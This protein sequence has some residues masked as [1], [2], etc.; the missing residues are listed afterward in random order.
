MEELNSYTGL[1]FSVRNVSPSAEQER[2]YDNRWISEPERNLMLAV[3][4]DAIGCFLNYR[5]GDRN[6][7]N[8]LLY[9]DARD[10]INSRS[11]YSI[12]AFR[13]LCEIVGINPDAL[14]RQLHRIRRG[15]SPR[16]VS[17]QRTFDVR[18]PSMSNT[19]VGARART[20]RA[21]APMPV[22]AGLTHP[23][24]AIA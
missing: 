9:A 20:R 22:S 8:R 14:K 1:P 10:W 16:S 17:L 13:N 23:E 21:R 11:R 2:C 5:D 12:F 3:L 19:K 15:E 18:S 6:A 7:R 24:L 4:E